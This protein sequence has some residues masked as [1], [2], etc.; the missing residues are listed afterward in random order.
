VVPLFF[1]RKIIKGHTYSP[2]QCNTAFH[3]RQ[4]LCLSVNILYKVHPHKNVEE[5]FIT[6]RRDLLHK[7]KSGKAVYD[8]VPFISYQILSSCAVIYSFLYDNV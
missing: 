7:G 1:Q 8:L 3:L 5:A 4:R 2:R 6:A